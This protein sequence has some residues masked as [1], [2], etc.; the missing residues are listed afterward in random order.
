MIGLDAPVEQ[1][2]AFY[3]GWVEDLVEQAVEMLLS[4]CHRQGKGDYFRVLYGRLCDQ[5]PMADVAELLG[6]K[7]TSAENY[8]KAARKRRSAI[9]HE[10]VQQHVARYAGP[11]QSDGQPD[12]QEFEAEWQQLG[13]YLSTHGGLEEAVRR[14]YAGIDP[15]RRRQ[16]KTEQIDL[17]LTRIRQRAAELSA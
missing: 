14:A 5:L 16:S 8:F 13:Q 4:E 11:G 10:L 1:I 6:I 15:V 9:L 17:T 3:A 2:D 12:S 7:L